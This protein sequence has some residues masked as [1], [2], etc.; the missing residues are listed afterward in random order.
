MPRVLHQAPEADH[1]AR[2]IRGIDTQNRGELG[3]ARDHEGS[4]PLDRILGCRD[5]GVKPVPIL[6]GASQTKN[7]VRLTQPNMPVCTK[8]GGALP[9]PGQAIEPSTVVLEGGL[10]ITSAC[11]CVPEAAVRHQIDD[12]ARVVRSWERNGPK[13]RDEAERSGGQRLG[14]QTPH[15]PTPVSPRRGM[16]GTRSARAPWNGRGG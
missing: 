14:H 9:K 2:E 6:T 4:Q 7:E 11:F 15:E 1:L 13:M 5:C 10:A 3:R 12:A 16:R 8:I